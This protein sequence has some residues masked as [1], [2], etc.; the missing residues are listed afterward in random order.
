MRLIRNADVRNADVRNA[1]AELVA[2]DATG[3]AQTVIIPGE[4]P[5]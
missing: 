3:G 5:A 2:M 4:R 1:D